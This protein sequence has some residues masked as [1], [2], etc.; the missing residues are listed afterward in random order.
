MTADF[1]L[2]QSFPS[3]LRHTQYSAA[4]DIAPEEQP[5]LRGPLEAAAQLGVKEMQ[6]R[7]QGIGAQI[8]IASY[9]DWR[10]FPSRSTRAS[11]SITS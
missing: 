10:R 2:Q 1:D 8:E 7:M 3:R 6:A 9:R 11:T 5:Q 4:L